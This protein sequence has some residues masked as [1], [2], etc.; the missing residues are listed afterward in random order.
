[1][2]RITAAQRKAIE[3]L[4]QAKI[5]SAPVPVER[6]ARLLNAEIHLEPFAGELYGMVHKN[7]DG[8]A[9]IGVNSLDAPTRRRFTIAH[10]IGHLLLHSDEHLHIDEKFPIRLQRDEKS[11]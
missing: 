3:F 7:A 9:V 4:K 2:P 11:S 6:L 1:M 10:E 5:R 8:K